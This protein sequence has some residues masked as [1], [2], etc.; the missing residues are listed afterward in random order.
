MDASGQILISVR[1]CGKGAVV[2]VDPLTGKQLVVATGFKV[3]M[4]IAIERDHGT[5]LVGDEWG[6]PNWGYL[7]RIDLDARTM[8]R[9]HI[10]QPSAVA[11]S[12]A[13]D[14]KGEV[15]LA[16]RTIYRWRDGS[17]RS[18]G[19]DDLDNIHA[20]TITPQGEMYIAEYNGGPVMHMRVGTP[21]PV[22]TFQGF[23]ATWSA[24]SSRDGKTVFF[25]SNGGTGGR[26]Y[27]LLTGDPK[28]RPEEVWK[29]H[30]GG[31]GT[32]VT[33]VGTVSP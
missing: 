4:G 6:R 21:K 29:G 23:A 28:A 7:W 8:E 24:A 30:P 22:E 18:V 33:V 3:P 9:L 32:F 14:P 27:R 15:F 31:L 25:G 10:F 1:P 13:I 12:I 19:F 11:T 5:I 2:R 20:M 26:V 17:P 16:A